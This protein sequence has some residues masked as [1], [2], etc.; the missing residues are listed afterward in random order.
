MAQ[1]KQKRNKRNKKHS[2]V[3][4]H[5]PRI[6]MET[7]MAEGNGTGVN[8]DIPQDIEWNDSEPIVIFECSQ[9]TEHAEGCDG[10][11]GSRVLTES[12]VNLINEGRAY[13]RANMSFLGIPQSMTM[14]G[15]P[16][17]N[18]ELFDLYIRVQTLQEVVLDKLDMDLEEFDEIFR[19]NK[20]NRLREVRE[21]IEPSL[22]EAR[23]KQ[24]LGVAHKP[25]LGPDGRPIG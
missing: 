13:A 21:S 2:V 5:R 12:M 18:V 19:T 9:H 23:L 24:Q 14:L 20:F 25:I 22:K 3:G 7:P 8:P 6:V 16:G 15:I 10:D 11:C 17:Q 1:S 4:T